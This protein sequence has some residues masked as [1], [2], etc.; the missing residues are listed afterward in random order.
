MAHF[1]S[2]LFLFL[3]PL[4]KF[5]LHVVFTWWWL[6]LPFLLFEKFKF[7]W[8]WWRTD[9]FLTLNHWSLLEIKVPQDVDNPFRRM[10][11]VLAGIWQVRIG[12]NKR[13]RWLEGK[14]QFGVSLEIAS[15]EGKVHFYLR[16]ENDDLELLRTS[17]YAQFPNAEITP[18]EDYSKQVP[19]D[20]P[21]KDWNLWA[22][23]YQSTKDD[24]YPIKTYKK[25][26]EEQ[27]TTFEEEPIRVDPMGQLLEGMAKLGPGEQLWV[28][29]F[30]SPR[31][32]S[33]HL[34][35]LKAKAEK[36]INQIV[37][38]PEKK[39]PKT[40][41]D[42]ARA[43][44]FHL[45][46]GKP[47]TEE[48]EKESILPPEMRI[49]PGEREVVLGIEEKMSKVMFECFI[50]SVYVARN[51]AYDG[52][53]KATPMSY[54]NQFTTTHMNGI[55]VDSDTWTKVHTISTWF[56]DKR[57]LYLRKR[58]QVRLYRERF[59][60]T[61]PRPGGMFFLNIEEI[62]TL[63]HFPGKLTAPS[64]GLPRIEAKRGEAP[65]QLPIE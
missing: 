14:V 60:Q 16:S 26:F 11:T 8:L 52:G 19:A 34:Q 41:T 64:A 20:I 12:S 65:P 24:V 1:F 25:F 57:R 50:R 5:F 39:G 28:Q 63:F 13:E 32:P 23:V 61:W 40:A 36:T 30:I 10:E 6:F 35:P 3:I 55:S 2:F 42:D 4:L 58:R 47:V 37:R 27:P 48:E 17:I 56:L 45:A 33:Q 62:A 31:I 46:T 43:V 18:A 59:E 22:S 15:I 9:H 54:F 7:F 49:T 44:F 29:I 21:N 51:D 53:V 38:R